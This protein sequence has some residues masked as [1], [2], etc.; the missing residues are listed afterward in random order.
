MPLPGTPHSSHSVVRDMDTFCNVQKA[1]C[2]IQ[3]PEKITSFILNRFPV[4]KARTLTL[5]SKARA[6]RVSSGL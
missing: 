2:G 6:S 3:Y 1:G 4:L 5:I